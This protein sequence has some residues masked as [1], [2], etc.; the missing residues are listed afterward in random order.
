MV[1]ALTRT[2]VPLSTLTLKIKSVLR[3]IVYPAACESSSTA[4]V[5]CISLR[6]VIENPIGTQAARRYGSDFRTVAKSAVCGIDVL[7]QASRCD[8]LSP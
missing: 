5:G 3:D 1:V 7:R 2:R 8:Y 6:T 4:Y